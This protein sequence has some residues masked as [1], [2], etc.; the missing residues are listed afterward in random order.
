MS[1]FIDQAIRGGD[2]KES[3]NIKKKSLHF[4]MSLC[5]FLPWF[6]KSEQSQRQIYHWYLKQAPDSEDL[7]DFMY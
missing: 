3:K 6:R 5:R 1:R 4:K 7:S 2:K